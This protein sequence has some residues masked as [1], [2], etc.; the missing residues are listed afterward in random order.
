MSDRYDVILYGLRGE[1]AARETAKAT[2]ARLL[3]LDPEAVERGL[4]DPEGLVVQTGVPETVVRKYQSAIGKLGGLSRFRPSLAGAAGVTA[5]AEPAAATI[6]GSTEPEPE[7]LTVSLGGL[8]LAPLAGET[9]AEAAAETRS[10]PAEP[11]PVSRFTGIELEL[12]GIDA[13][14]AEPSAEARAEPPPPAPAPPGIALSLEPDAADAEEMEAVELTDPYPPAAEGSHGG[15]ATLPFTFDFSP[16]E[17]EAPGSDPAAPAGPAV[18]AAS[19]APPPAPDPLPPVDEDESARIRRR[20]AELQQ[21]RELH[22]LEEG[23]HPAQQLRRRHTDLHPEPTQTV[24]KGKTL[25]GMPVVAGSAI[26]AVGLLMGA[27]IAVSMLGRG[28]GAPAGAP[29]SQAETPASAP[30][31][32]T[33]LAPGQEALNQLAAFA[34]GLPEAAAE[35]PAPP[36]AAPPESPSSLTS[37]HAETGELT[38]TGGALAIIK[39]VIHPAAALEDLRRDHT[40]DR[41]LADLSARLLRSNQP[42]RA[43]QTAQAMADGRAKWDAMMAVAEHYQRL[44]L[45]PGRDRVTAQFES[46]LDTIDDKP[47][48]IQALGALARKLADFGEA[49]H[50]AELSKRAETMAGELATRSAKISGRCFLAGLQQQLGQ[51]DKADLGW[52]EVN[53]II[54]EETYPSTRLGHYVDLANG[55][56]QAAMEGTARGL[57]AAIGPLIPRLPA[58]ERP[59]LL[60]GLATAYAAVGDVDAALAAIA[61]LPSSEERDLAALALVRDRIAAGNPY[62]ALQAAVTLTQAV[63]RTRAEAAVGWSLQTRGQE[64]LARALLVHVVEQIDTIGNPVDKVVAMATVGRY[65]YWADQSQSFPLLS[66]SSAAIPL[67]TDPLLR[68]QA[69]AVVAT[70]FARS[71]QGPSAK[72]VQAM[73]SDPAIASSTAD[74]VARIGRAFEPEPQEPAAPRPPSPPPPQ[75]N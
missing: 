8:S 4:A 2:I 65:Q 47:L 60:T 3:K 49:A 66:K 33:T 23:I 75:V 71:G 64:V 70:E 58:A 6:A 41:H 40:W 57:L 54:A 19:E 59:P 15:G 11:A 45:A 44:G 46:G 24:T 5:A 56:S 51:T 72:D 27:G 13:T 7:R 73:I 43:L 9:E 28:S 63:H 68:D 25:F 18:P 26:W 12:E 53:R 74:E 20:M 37:V 50:A 16:S 39:P 21:I 35:P 61:R 36:S 22:A 1:G 69:L 62:T 29:P 34:A 52:R 48:R 10:G 55:Y 38:I 17:E 67:I 30:G 31:K 42:D 32:A 14:A